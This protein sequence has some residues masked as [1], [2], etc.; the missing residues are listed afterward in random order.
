MFARIILATAAMAVFAAVPAF[1]QSVVGRNTNAVGPFPDGFY[2]GIPHYQDNEPH[3][4]RNPLLESNIVCMV[5]GY[6]GA[7][8]AIGDG[9]PKILETAGQCAHL[10]VAFHDRQPRRP[11]K[12]AGTRFRSRPDHGLLARWLRWFLSSPRTAPRAAAAAAASTCSCCPNSTWRRVSGIYSEQGPR[13]I[14]LGHRRQLP[15]QDR[16]R[17]HRRRTESGHGRSEYRDRK[18]QRR[19]GG[20]S[21]AAGRRAGSSSFTHRSTRARRTSVSSRRI[22]TTMARTGARRN[23]SR[24]RPVSIPVSLSL[25]YRIPSCMPTGSLPMTAA[26][27]STR[28]RR[29]LDHGRSEH[30]QAVRCRRQPL[31]VRSA[32]PC[33]TGRRRWQPGGARCSRVAL[34]QLRRREH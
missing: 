7:D 32:D 10:V 5:N 2:K 29:G 24:I 9:W 28:F 6:N 25:R 13:T 33:D 27:R 15:R 30:R 31:P 16:R 1:A 19:H 22:P 4:D 18:R 11:D 3:C 26:I 23:R 14:Q 8:D 17:F 12:L 21:T 34:E 20:Q